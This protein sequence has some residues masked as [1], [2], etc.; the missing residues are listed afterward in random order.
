MNKSQLA[1]WEQSWRGSPKS[2]LTNRKVIQ[3]NR[4]KRRG[5]NLEMECAQ[6]LIGLSQS[7]FLMESI[8]KGKWEHFSGLC[9]KARQNGNHVIVVALGVGRLGRL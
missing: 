4:P 1:V 2:R 8:A 9:A 3:P 5:R 7:A 6:D